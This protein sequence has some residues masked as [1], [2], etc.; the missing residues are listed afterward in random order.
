[1]LLCH[2]TTQCQS[3]EDQ[4][5]QEIVSDVIIKLMR[6][7]WFAELPSGKK[8]GGC[9]DYLAMCNQNEP[10]HSLIFPASL[11]SL[12][13]RVAKLVDTSATC[14]NK[15]YTILG[16]AN[17]V[18]ISLLHWIAQSQSCAYFPSVFQESLQSLIISRFRRS[19]AH[20][21]KWNYRAW[22]MDPR[23]NDS[24]RSRSP[25]GILRRVDWKTLYA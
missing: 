3:L 24:K 16:F 4:T 17:E 18:A 9:D 8:P 7:Q 14:Q 5:I 6:V 12:Y 19:F 22:K 11:A 2:K 23:T 10:L 15:R 20:E 25:S 1:M 21:A 13:C